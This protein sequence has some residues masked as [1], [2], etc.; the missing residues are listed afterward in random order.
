MSIV[1]SSYPLETGVFFM[2]RLR[3]DIIDVPGIKVGH[4]TDTESVTGCTVVICPSN[5]VGGVDVRGASPGTRETDLLRPE[6]RVQE[7]HAVLLG[8][9]SAFGLAAADGVMKYLEER[10]VG[11]RAG[12][13]IVPIVPSAILFDLGLG[14]SSVRPDK[15]SG[16]NACVDSESEE[17]LQGSVGVGTGATVGKTSKFVDSCKGGVGSS[18]RHVSGG[19]IVGALMAV[20]SV[21]SV[22]NPINGRLIAGPKDRNGVMMSAEQDLMSCRSDDMRCDTFNTTIGVIATNARLTKDQAS[23]LATSGHDGIALSVRPAHLSG[24]GDTIF[25]LATKNE[26]DH[27]IGLSGTYQIDQLLAS[28]AAC[29]SEAIVKAVTNAKGMGGIS[30]VGDLL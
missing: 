18:S 10:S 26:S 3:D 14:D 23:R 11:F 6:N 22:H 27:G 19:V 25:S 30:G 8:G 20:N 4:W 2:H 28:A 7:V 9:G 16:Y 17:L 21:G 12:K 29:T 24:D 13:H 1:A 5:T 15:C